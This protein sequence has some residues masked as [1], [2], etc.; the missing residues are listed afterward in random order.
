MP[1][2]LDHVLTQGSLTGFETEIN[3]SL[4]ASWTSQFDES[5]TMAATS[6]TGTPLAPKTPSPND[7]IT[8]GQRMFSATAGNILTGLLGRR[9]SNL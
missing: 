9:T 7:D 6:G 8:V 2:G 1:T 4:G 5:T 3:A